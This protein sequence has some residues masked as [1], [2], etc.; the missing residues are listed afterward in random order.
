MSAL[1]PELEVLSCDGMGT[2]IMAWAA[3]ILR[4][5]GTAPFCLL[6]LLLLGMS[7]DHLHA[8]VV[9]EQPFEPDFMSDEFKI[10]KGSDLR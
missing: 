2:F 3:K 4:V 7:M 9:A 8:D 10:T 6:L 5:P 1:E